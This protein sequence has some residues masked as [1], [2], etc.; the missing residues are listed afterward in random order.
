MNALLHVYINLVIPRAILRRLRMAEGERKQVGADSLADTSLLYHG[1]CHFLF[2]RLVHGCQVFSRMP[3]IKIERLLNRFTEGRLKLVLAHRQEII[4]A[5]IIHQWPLG[6]LFLLHDLLLPAT[7]SQQKYTPTKLF[8]Q[9][10]LNLT[11]I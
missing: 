7:F 1:I 3:G 8:L 4:Q 9:R 2:K 5:L 11:S 10:S 6:W